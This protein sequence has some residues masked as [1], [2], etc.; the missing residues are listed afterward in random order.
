MK[1][2]KILFIAII[3]SLFS[4]SCSDDF[5]EIAPED[6]LSTGNF[7]NTEGDLEAA[8]VA[9]YN[10]WKRSVIWLPTMTE[11]RSDNLTASTLL[12]SQYLR[13]T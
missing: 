4:Q 11:F 3:F 2:L 5:L 7:Y 8:I 1:I 13:I 6:A 12:G 10:S 9:V